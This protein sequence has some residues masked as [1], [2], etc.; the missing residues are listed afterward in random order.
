MQDNTHEFDSS[1]AATYAADGDA[2]N[3]RLFDFPKRC[4]PGGAYAPL[5]TDRVAVAAMR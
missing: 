1:N 3:L 2:P 4:K 5:P